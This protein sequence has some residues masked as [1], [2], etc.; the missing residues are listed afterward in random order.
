[1]IKVNLGSGFVGLDGW[2]NYD[3]SILAKLSKVPGMISLLIKLG[4]LYVGY[5]D[6]KWPPIIIHDCTKG[7]PLA[8]G[9]VTFIY[10]SHFL[11]HLYRYQVLALLK[12]CHRVLKEGCRLRI[13]LPDIDRIIGLYKS[14]TSASLLKGH[15]DETV[16]FVES[17]YF[18]ANF[19]SQ[20]M[21][22]AAKPGLVKRLS[23]KFLRRHLWMY[24][25]ESITTLLRAAGF[26]KIEER[27]FG[28]SSFP[29]CIKLDAHKEVSF[30]IEAEK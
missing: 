20:D 11:E 17:D 14:G 16:A 25:R 29:E 19:F 24:T 9:S 26:S 28:D 22:S 21:N 10:T 2:H 5:R 15:K 4:L 30:Y 12:E 6:V 18:C 27:A 13:V 7:I 1:M 23:E 3:N 8:D